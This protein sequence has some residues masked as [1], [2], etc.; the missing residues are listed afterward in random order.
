MKKNIYM[1]NCHFAVQQKLNTTLNTNLKLN[2]NQLYFNK[3]KPHLQRDAGE[4]ALDTEQH[5]QKAAELRQRRREYS[6]FFKL[7][8]W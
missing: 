3:I 4:G 5:R 7:L 2:T 8:M 1:Y 6:Q